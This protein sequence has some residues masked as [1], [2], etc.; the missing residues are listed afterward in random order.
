LEVILSVSRVGFKKPYG[1]TG[2]AALAVAQLIPQRID[3]IETIDF[4]GN[5][6]YDNISLVGNRVAGWLDVVARFPVSFFPAF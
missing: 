1:S 2:R 6:E 5:A 4:V 3:S